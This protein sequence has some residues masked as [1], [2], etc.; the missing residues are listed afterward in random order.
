MWL[1]SHPTS[2]VVFLPLPITW[3]LVSCCFIPHQFFA[4]SIPF[5]MILSLALPWRPQRVQ[6]LLFHFLL[7]SPSRPFTPNPLCQFGPSKL[8]GSRLLAWQTQGWYLPREREALGTGR[9]HRTHTAAPPRCFQLPAHP[10]SPLASRARLPLRDSLFKALSCVTLSDA[11][12]SVA[13]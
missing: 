2:L 4:G 5:K 7:P 11:H 13:L 8:G 6:L 9:T 3:L 1:E 10:P 12:M